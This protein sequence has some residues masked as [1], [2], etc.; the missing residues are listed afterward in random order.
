MNQEIYT[1][2]SILCDDLTV[3]NYDKFEHTFI[4]P[5]YDSIKEYVCNHVK[6]LQLQMCSVIVYGM[7]KMRQESFANLEDHERY[8]RIEDLKIS[9]YKNK[10]LSFDK[11]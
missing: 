2:C 6:P 11:L 7:L 8:Y 4:M 3:A 10:R 9:M 5:T 1:T